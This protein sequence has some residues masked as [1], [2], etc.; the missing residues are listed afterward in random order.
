MPSAFT[1]LLPVEP[2]ARLAGE[3]FESV[4]SVIHQTEHLTFN[5]GAAAGAKKGFKE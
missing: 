3:R 5:K 1:K 4:G 2:A